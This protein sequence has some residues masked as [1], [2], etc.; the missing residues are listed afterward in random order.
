MGGLKE[1]LL[2]HHPAALVG[3]E[4]VWLEPVLQRIAS[5]QDAAGPVQ[6]QNPLG[7]FSVSEDEHAAAGR[8]HLAI[9]AELPVGH[10][11]MLVR[12]AGQRPKPRAIA[13]TVEGV[14]TAM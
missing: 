14:V 12:H 13:R 3:E 1:L 10:E 4:F 11:A 5:N 7:Q 9:G 8:W 2:R 6:T